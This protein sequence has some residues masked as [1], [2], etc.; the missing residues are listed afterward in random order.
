MYEVYAK[1]R[2]KIG[3]KDTQVARLTGVAQSTFS[4]WKHG[5]SS[6][7]GEKLKRIAEFFGVTVDYLMTGEEKEDYYLDKD[8]RELVQFLYDNPEYRTLFSTVRTVRK[9][10]IAFVRDFIDRITKYQKGEEDGVQRDI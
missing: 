8:A 6:P 10:D 1:L 4:D 9:E 5:R 7:K 3:L 2:D